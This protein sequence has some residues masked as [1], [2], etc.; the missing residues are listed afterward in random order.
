MTIF[1]VQAFNLLAVLTDAFDLPD[2]L[3]SQ[4]RKSAPNGELWSANGQRTEVNRGCF[5]GDDVFGRL[6][7]KSKIQKPL[8][9]V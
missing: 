5:R 6:E 2:E 7:V 4:G 9:Q 3:A 8:R 1:S